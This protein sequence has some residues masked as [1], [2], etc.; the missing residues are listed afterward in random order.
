M[1][2]AI[3]KGKV[4][5][6]YIEELYERYSNAKCAREKQIIKREFYSLK[7]KIKEIV[8]DKIW[9]QEIVRKGGYYFYE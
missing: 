5:P 6:V 9:V 2:K 8:L 7:D 3:I 4:N 1:T